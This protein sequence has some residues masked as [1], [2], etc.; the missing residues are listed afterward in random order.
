MVNVDNR[1]CFVS[2]L[3]TLKR[4]VDRTA[5]DLETTRAEVTQMKKEV[6]EKQDK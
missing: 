4:T 3:E 2:Q 5:M 6:A 1:I